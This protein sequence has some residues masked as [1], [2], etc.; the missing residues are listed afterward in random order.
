MRNLLIVCDYNRMGA[1]VSITKAVVMCQSETGASDDIVVVIE[2][3]APGTK[4]ST[5]G[6]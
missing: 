2:F 1:T 3:Q 6:R 4:A 5:R